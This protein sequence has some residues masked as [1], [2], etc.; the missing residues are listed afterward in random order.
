MRR[1]VSMT[2][3]G[4]F[5][6]KEDK[7]VAPAIAAI[8]T[9]DI[10]ALT[11][12]LSGDPALATAYIGT[13]SEA[14][15]LLHILADWPGNLAA[16]PDAARALI[17]AG[18]DV[19]AP[20]VGDAHSE[21]PLHWAASNDDVA[22]LDVLLDAGA[23]IDASGGVIA[24]TPLADARAFLQLKTAHRLVERGARV[25]LQDAATLGLQDRVEAVFKSPANRPSQEDIDRAL[26]NAC[27]GGQLKMA[28]Y[29]HLQGGAI[30]FVPPWE[31]LTPLDA[32]RR[33]GAADVTSWLESLEARQFD[34]SINQ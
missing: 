28:Q 4:I 1:I 34:L 21:T 10:D 2:D 19:M 12:C 11:A 25:T 15:T 27:H 16:G 29:L 7:R 6:D 26:W 31:Q 5:I 14:R 17:A 22:L 3:A 33:N 30:D 24:E 20:F 18:A 23:D 13:S 9:G 32:A 8:R